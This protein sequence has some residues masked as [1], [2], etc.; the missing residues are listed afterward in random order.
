MSWTGKAIGLR[1]CL[2]AELFSDLTVRK[3]DRR[4]VDFCHRPR[5]EAVK[6]FLIERF[7]GPAER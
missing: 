6:A 2:D 4:S 1:P 5:R 7:R 3:L